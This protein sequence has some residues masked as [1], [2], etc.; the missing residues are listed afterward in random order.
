[1]CN[2]FGV[3]VQAALQ[4]NSVENSPSREGTVPKLVKNFL[5][6]YGA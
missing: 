6:F 3:E 5:A 4:T 1:M 2:E